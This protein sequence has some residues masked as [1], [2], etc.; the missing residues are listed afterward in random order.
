MSQSCFSKIRKKYFSDYVIKGRGDSFA[1]CSIC[2]NLKQIR[3]SFAP[4]SEDYERIQKQFDKHLF[5]QEA[6][7]NVYYCSRWLSNLRPSQVLSIMHDKMDHSKT[8][9][10]A[11]AR[12]TKA[13]EGFMKLPMKVTGMFAHGHG[14]GKYAHFSLDVFPSDSNFT[15][16]S[17]AKL[18]RDLEDPPVKSSRL[19]F[20][21][22]GSTM[23]YRALLRGSEVCMDS[24]GRV[25]SQP[26][27]ARPLP[28]VLHIQMDNS[29]RENKNR[30]VFC[31]WSL[32]VARRIVKEVVVSF[33]IVGHTHDDIDASFGR[34][35]M[36]LREKDHPTLP[37]LMQSYMNMEAVPFIP[38]LIEEVADFKSYI[39]PYIGI[40]KKQLVGHSKGRQYKFFMDDN[41]WPIMQY[42]LA[43][44]NLAW[45]PT[46]GVKLWKED[47]EHKPIFPRGDPL[48]VKPKK[49]TNEAEILRGLEGY[50]QHWMDKSKEDGTLEYKAQMSYLVTYWTDVRN[51]MRDGVEQRT[52]HANELMQG[53]WPRT[54]QP[55]DFMTD[56]MQ[57]GSMREEVGIE[58]PYIGTLEGR[59]P[60]AYN[61][62]TDVREGFYLFVRPALDSEDPV[63]LG[64]A[65]ENPQ[66]DPEADHYREV[67]VQW[68]K[69]CG[70]STDPQRL[71][72]G[73]DTKPNFKWK[74]DQLA[75]C[76]DYIS[77]DSIMA[78]WQ[79]RKNT[80][81]EFIAPRLQVK[82]AV[83]NL[84]RIAEEER[85]ATLKSL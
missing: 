27:E 60:Q 14:D 50:I 71:Y 66:F 11:L 63:W 9:C 80:G 7:R 18:L 32:L 79:P 6:C 24:L 13:L 33:M 5:L 35:S 51:A 59:P 56:L 62:A 1:R 49:M 30:Y 36:E 43:C 40:N 81:N 15:I 20:R 53:F 84:R 12:K 73:W 76:F 26:I 44:T 77:T 16:A 69:P 3:A 57:D 19:L 48:P 54:R 2:D 28:P 67:L 64:R 55:G 25:P 41:G 58:D 78:S 72:A 37:L 38:H 31:F 22:S 21:G 46:E 4:G 61:V 52:S 85:R 75:S 23:L 42:K 47:A 29:W 68:H 17:I 70:M 39:K 74:I 10:P 82:F 8:A 34:W 65:M 45:L 83:D